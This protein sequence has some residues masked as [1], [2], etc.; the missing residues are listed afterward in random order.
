MEYQVIEAKDEAGNL[1]AKVKQEIE[2]GW[3]PVGGVAVA[4]SPQSYN[5]WFY[6]PMTREA[7]NKAESNDVGG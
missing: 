2:E 4:Y 1:Q 6:Q 5:W 3:V 7:G